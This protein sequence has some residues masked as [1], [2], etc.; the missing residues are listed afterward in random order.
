MSEFTCQ[1][2]RFVSYQSSRPP[3]RRAAAPAPAPGA[4]GPPR[5]SRAPAPRRAGC[6]Y[7]KSCFKYPLRNLPRGSIRRLRAM[8]SSHR[9]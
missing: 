8:K 3:P 2:Y 1:K 7:S 9:G 6:A 5:A 4:S